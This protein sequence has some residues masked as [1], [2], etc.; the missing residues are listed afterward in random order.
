VYS[1]LLAL[2]KLLLESGY[3]V[4]VDAAFLEKSE[5]RRFETMAAE[6]C[7][8]F[9]IAALKASRQT[10]MSRILSRENDASEAGIDVLDAKEKSSEPL[11]GEELH[12]VADFSESVAQWDRLLA[13]IGKRA[14][15][16]L[17]G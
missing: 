12:H 13:I 10:L 2:A 16:S 17:P 14:P 8:P 3:P 15:V 1:H 5:R 9:A 11:D 7:V 4:I 6:H